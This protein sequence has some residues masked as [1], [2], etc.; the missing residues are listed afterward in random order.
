MKIYEVTGSVQSFDA[1]TGKAVIKT[2][3]GEQ[4]VDASKLTPN[5]QGQLELDTPKVSAGQSVNINT[6]ATQEDMPSDANTPA[7]QYIQQLTAMMQQYKQPWEQAQLKA[8][9]DA[10]KSGQVPKSATGGPI[11][12]LPPKEWEA[13][14]AKTNPALLTR[15]L[16][17]FGTSAYS[18]EYLQQH[19]TMSRG[20]DY[21]GLEEKIKDTIADGGGDIGG[22]ATDEFIKD[23]TDKKFTRANRPTGNNG[24]ASP[25]PKLK[26]TDEL[27]KWLTIAGIK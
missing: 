4:D 14:L 8:R 13:N 6:Q 9:L 27:Y 26:E 10:V 15:M 20:L 3:T 7:A 21:V 19:G 22:D 25:V 24:T 12:S 18:P 5:A 11:Q 16:G 2:P 1:N 23:V 17:V